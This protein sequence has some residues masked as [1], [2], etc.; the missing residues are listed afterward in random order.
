MVNTFECN[1]LDAAYALREEIQIT[2]N[3]VINSVTKS[4]ERHIMETPRAASAPTVPGAPWVSVPIASNRKRPPE[5]I[6]LDADSPAPLAPQKPISSLKSHFGQPVKKMRQT[7]MWS[8]A[9]DPAAE[10]QM[11]VAIADFILS[12]NY[13]FS[14]AEDEK[15]K[16]MIDVARKLPPNYKPPSAYKVGGELLT[17]LYDVNWERETNM[18]L[19]DSRT[20]GIS[21]YGDGATIKTYSKIN[22]CASGV[23]N[24]FSMLDVFDCT[25][26][27]AAGGIKDAPYISG[28]FVPLIQKLE[29]MA[30][31]FVSFGVLHLSHLC[32]FSNCAYFSNYSHHRLSLIH[33]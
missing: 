5:E 20:F 31:Q 21:I 12:K 14:L 32:S 6:V 33:I 18:L 28:L 23:Y 30:D 9:S 24:S 3:S 11:D 13:D 15:F 25:E 17:K 4:R 16:H 1:V 29:D 8:S 7:K 22:A 2:Q 27:M 19:K 26:H 10:L